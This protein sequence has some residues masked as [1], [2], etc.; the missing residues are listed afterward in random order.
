MKDSTEGVAKEQTTA[1][2]ES[3]VNTWAHGNETVEK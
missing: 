1:S 2:A 3:G